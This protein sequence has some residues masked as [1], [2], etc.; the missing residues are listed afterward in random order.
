LEIPVAI[1]ADLDAACD[2]AKMISCVEALGEC[3]ENISEITGSLS[4]VAR[5]VKNLPPTI[6]G[7]EVKE[8]LRTL[9]EL[10]MNWEA[11]DDNTIRRQLSE[12]EGRIKRF[13]R[14]KEGGIEAYDAQPEIKAALEELVRRCAEIGLFFVP[15]G[16]L[17]GWIPYLN[18]APLSFSLGTRRV[19]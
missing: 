19:R 12:L 4:D 13:Q 1:I 16:E 8:A 5:K 17:E 3:Q 18:S 6:T 15:C 7:D 10:P 9:V 14:L 2:S 11:G